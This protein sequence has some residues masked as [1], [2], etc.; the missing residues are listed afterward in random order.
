M[1]LLLKTLVTLSLFFTIQME[2]QIINDN[3]I[4]TREFTS[5]DEALKNPENV[6]RL[7]L[8]N[9]NVDI[10]SSD[11]AKFVN[12]EYL[13]LK[14]DQ[15]KKIPKEI[16]NL[17]Y[18][19]F[20]DLSG[21]DFDVLPSNFSKLQNLEV[22]FLNDETRMNLPKTLQILA[23]LPRLKTLHLENGHLKSLPKEIFK[24]QSLENLFLNE[25]DF[26][27]I[28]E[29]IEGLHHLQYLDLQNNNIL[30]ENQFTPDLNFGFKI[31]Y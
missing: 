21:N 9:Q 16:G 4:Q 25:N 7:N 30:P 17:K 26:Q 10:S 28:P 29:K 5:L 23:K 3:S 15:L 2:S 24:L 14:N 20:L 13:S 6:V 22:L 12:L 31:N 8:D 18:L 27:G 19:K 1:K 11:W